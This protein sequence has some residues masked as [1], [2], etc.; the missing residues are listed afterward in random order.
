MDNILLKIQHSVSAWPGRSFRLS[1]L[2]ECKNAHSVIHWLFIYIQVISN[3]NQK[4]KW[5]GNKFTDILKN[6]NSVET[7]S[8]S[9]FVFLSCIKKYF[10]TDGRDF[11]YP[12]ISEGAS[13]SLPELISAALHRLLCD[14]IRSR[15]KNKAKYFSPWAKP[16][17]KIRTASAI[18]WD[19]IGTFRDYG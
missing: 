4:E 12:I 6:L 15:F 16:S 17:L 14:Q 9:S 7:K 2:A 5:L 18:F 8:V 19:Y 3:L 11:G 13:L 1:A 10:C